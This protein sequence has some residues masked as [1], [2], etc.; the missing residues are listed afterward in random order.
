[1]GDPLAEIDAVDGRSISARILLSIVALP[2]DSRVVE[3]VRERIPRRSRWRVFQRD[4]VEVG[5]QFTPHRRTP[6]PGVSSHER[7]DHLIV[8]A[9]T[10]N[11]H[12][13]WFDGLRDGIIESERPRQDL[14]PG[15]RLETII[16]T[17]QAHGDP[18]SVALQRFH[19]EDILGGRQECLDLPDQGRSNF[20]SFHDGNDGREL[21]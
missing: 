15:T 6:L 19:P 21:G 20:L 17:A 3:R 18:G 13:V 11:R 10:G 12:G 2:D 5:E 4:F 14:L 16:L 8:V 1:M 9:E 7:P